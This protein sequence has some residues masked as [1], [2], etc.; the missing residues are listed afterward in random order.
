MGRWAWLAAFAIVQLYGILDEIH[1]IWIPDRSCYLGD[2][3]ADGLGAAL[4]VWLYSACFVQRGRAGR[5]E[6]N[7]V[8]PGDL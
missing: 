8:P 5:V 4:G 6:A 2:V 1:Q 7:D 3:V